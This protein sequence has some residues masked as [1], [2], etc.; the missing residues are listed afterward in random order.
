V[1]DDSSSNDPL[2]WKNPR[3]CSGAVC[4]A[5]GAA[6]RGATIGYTTCARCRAVRLAATL[7]PGVDL[8]TLDEPVAIDVERSLNGA[9]NALDTARARLADVARL[10]A[11]VDVPD[12]DAVRRTFV[13]ADVGSAVGALA[14]QPTRLGAFNTLSLTPEAAADV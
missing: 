9:V 1:S 13:A 6:P 10:R 8:T 5:P 14:A 3:T 7:L 11:T 2:A 12:G 4:T